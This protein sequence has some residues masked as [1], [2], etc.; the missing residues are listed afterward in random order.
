M[1][2]HVPGAEEK[3]FDLSSFS[4]TMTWRGK[5][6]DEAFWLKAFERH[7]WLAL[8]GELEPCPKRSPTSA[9]A[10]ESAA[11]IGGSK[12]GAPQSRPPATSSETPTPA[13]SSEAA[14][15]KETLRTHPSG[16]TC[17]PSTPNLGV[18]SWI[19]S[20]EG[21]R[22]SLGAP[23]EL[24]GRQKTS[25]GSG[26]P[27]RASFAIVSHDKPSSWKTYR[28]W[29]TEASTTFSGTWPKRGSM[30]SGGCIE[31]SMSGL[32][33]EDLGSSSSPTDPLSLTDF[34]EPPSEKETLEH[35]PHV[36]P[37]AVTTDAQSA[38]RHTTKTGV[39]RPGTMLTDAMRIFLVEVQVNLDPDSHR[40][41]ALKQDGRDTSQQAVLS[42]LFVEALM[43]YPTAWT[44]CASLETPSSPK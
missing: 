37:T 6:R 33:T 22:A 29:Q 32:P 12:E 39:M 15:E 41:H 10:P 38:A 31:L 2:I 28:A 25:D 13:P 35:Y 30:L 16:P 8:L 1:W 20:L 36:W 11:L 26:Q 23:Q 18:E 42:P 40:L 7:E 3:P 44:V 17:S 34:F 27:S 14:F 21:S 43:G 5:K 24:K 4:A 9:C 19:S